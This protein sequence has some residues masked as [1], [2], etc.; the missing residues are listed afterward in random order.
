MVVVVHEATEGRDLGMCSWERTLIVFNE[1]I[2][3]SLYMNDQAESCSRCC[4]EL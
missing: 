3:I 2:Y 4:G 1:H